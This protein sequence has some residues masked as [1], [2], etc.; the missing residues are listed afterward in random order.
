MRQFFFCPFDGLQPSRDETRH[1]PCFLLWQKGGLMIRAL[2][3]LTVLLAS[4]FAMA[5]TSAPE[6]KPKAFVFKYH[7][8]GENLEVRR[9]V[10]SYEQ[11]FEQA[12]QTCFDHYR[13]NFG[14]KLTED[15]GLDIIDVCANPRS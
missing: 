5:A 7:Y 6:V 13:R 10:A 4:T 8:Q 1:L 11:A 14:G 15:Q 3:T 2:I 9:Q 12:A